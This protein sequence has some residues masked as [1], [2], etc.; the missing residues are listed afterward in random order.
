MNTMKYMVISDIHGDI[1]ALNKVIDLYNKEDCSKLLILGDLFSYA[2]DSS[3]DDIINTLNDIKNNIICVRGNCDYYINGILFDMPNINTITINNKLIT[4]TH[5]HLYNKNELIDM[6]SD[7]IFV[8]HTHIANVDT[9]YNKLIVNPGSI[10]KS[11][12]GENSFALIDND[13]ITIRNLDNKIIFE[14]AF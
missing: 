7:I 12:K 10:S 3:R 8:G 14:Q 4:M 1:I 5:G 9:I 11:R 6:K 13:T 2:S